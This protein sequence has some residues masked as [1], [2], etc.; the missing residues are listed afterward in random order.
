MLFSLSRYLK[1][2]LDFLVMYK[3]SLIRKTRLISELMRSKPGKQI[4][5][6][7]TLSNFLRIKGN[8]RIES[9]QLKQCNMTNIFLENSYTKCGE[10]TIPRPFFKKKSKLNISLDHLSIVLYNLFWLGSKWRAIKIYW[11]SAAYHLLYLRLS[12]FFKKKALEFVSL[13]HFLHDF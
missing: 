1:V 6:I 13:P 3:N 4:I 8:Q 12:L 11:N 9:S 2:C 10:E 7:H 5:V